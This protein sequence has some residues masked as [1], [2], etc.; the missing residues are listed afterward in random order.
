MTTLYDI[1]ESV[2]LEAQNDESLF[3]GKKRIWINNYAKEGLS[4]LNMTLANHVRAMNVQI[5]SV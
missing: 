4:E 2:F 3:R 5:P 1:T